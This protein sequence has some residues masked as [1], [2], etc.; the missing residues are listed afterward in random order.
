MNDKK[1]LIALNFH[2]ADYD[3]TYVSEVNLEPV[4]GKVSHASYTLY[5]C[6][7]MRFPLW[8]VDNVIDYLTTL[9]INRKDVYIRSISVIPVD[10]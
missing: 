8:L 5:D 1:Y 7:A 2:N 3:G 10:E 6:N 9:M 4:T